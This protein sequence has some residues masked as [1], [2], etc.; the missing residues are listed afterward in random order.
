MP[1]LRAPARDGWTREPTNPFG[2][3]VLR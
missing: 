1:A 2:E 3:D